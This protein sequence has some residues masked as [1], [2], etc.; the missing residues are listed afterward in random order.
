MSDKSEKSDVIG[1]CNNLDFARVD[2]VTA[3]RCV[4]PYVLLK[5][6]CSIVESLK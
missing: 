2:K 5:K 6:R 3:E 1:K 4:V